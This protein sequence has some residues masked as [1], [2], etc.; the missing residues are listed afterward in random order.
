MVNMING[1]EADKQENIPLAVLFSDGSFV[2][3]SLYKNRDE[4]INAFV[5][6]CKKTKG[7]NLTSFELIQKVVE[8]AVSI[9]FGEKTRENKEMVKTIS[10]A[11]SADLVLKS[12]VLDFAKRHFQELKIESTL[13][14]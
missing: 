5:T 11:L 4:K 7:Y 1:A 3:E 8:N 13:I 6:L 12:E 2:D 9:E 14:N 10:D